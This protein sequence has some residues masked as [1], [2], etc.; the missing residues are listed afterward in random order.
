MTVGGEMDVNTSFSI[1]TLVNDGTVN[2]NSGTL[3]VQ[4]GSTND[5]SA[6]TG[7]A[8]FNVSQGAILLFDAN[9]F[10]VKSLPS[11]KASRSAERAWCGSVV[12]VSSRSTPM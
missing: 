7:S 8:T 1:P 3:E 12:Q 5:G 4:G 6:G 11:G 2:V 9:E 10:D